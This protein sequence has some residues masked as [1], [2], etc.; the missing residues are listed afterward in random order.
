MNSK[1]G[2]EGAGVMFHTEKSH[3]QSMNSR[4]LW[5]D[6]KEFSLADHIVVER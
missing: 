5:H 2:S 3:V 1:G 4:D 6:L